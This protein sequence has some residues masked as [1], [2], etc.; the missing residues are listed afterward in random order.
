M[1]LTALTGKK[2]YLVFLEIGTQQVAR[3]NGPKLP[4]STDTDVISLEM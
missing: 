2:N 1:S 4:A 3:R